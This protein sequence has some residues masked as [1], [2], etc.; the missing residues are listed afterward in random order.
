VSDGDAPAPVGDPPTYAQRRETA[1]AA[2]AAGDAAAAF[3]E[4]RWTL[5]YPRTV[6]PDELADALGVLA[7]IF[8]AMGYRELAER[9]AH[10][11]V[12][13][14]EPDGLYE[15]GYQLIEEG[16][17]AIASTVLTRCLALAPGT[18]QV[19]TEL[20]ASLE[21]NLAYG[22]ARRVLEAQPA[23]LD[24][25]FLCRYLH[26]F[27]AVMSG[28]LAAARA[29]LPR[30]IAVEDVED[31]MV[32]RISGMVGRADRAA[33][34]GARLDGK[35]LRGW[36]YVISGGVLAHLS[37]H[38]FDEGMHGR[39]A[40]LQ[41]SHALVRLGLERLRAAL[42]VWD[43]DVPCVYAPPGRDHEIVG[44]AAARLLGLPRAPWPAVGL[45][46]PGLVV[47]YDLVSLGRREIEQL[48]ERRPGQVLFAHVTPWT[49][50]TVIAADVTTLLGQ[51]VVPAWES[52]L[53][54]DHASGKAA[55]GATDE[56]DA[57][58]IGAAIAAAD[59]LP[60]EDRTLDDEPG[61]LAL[62]RAAGLAVGTRR[63]RGWA[64]GPVSSNRFL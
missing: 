61:F 47:A 15:L 35:D 27:N 22:D 31:V 18:E 37:P 59:P 64:G 14:L 45:P 21:R 3:R 24:E 30:L 23:L 38:G 56:R 5:W 44:E 51:R 26:A 40:W 4:F 12:T 53:V 32:D 39:Y 11:S 52:Q 49:E 9:A 57:A 16:L 2:L 55:P 29:D 43:A 46:A 17:P 60:S 54:F 34:A 33:G 62:A 19:I 50:D 58:A 25:S 20:V 63:E 42:A 28:E 36:H 10:V 41:D 6:A 8:V 1:L 13:P 7:R 48:L